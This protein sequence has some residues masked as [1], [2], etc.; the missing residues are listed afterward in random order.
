MAHSFTLI[1]FWHGPRKG[2]AGATNKLDGGVMPFVLD[3]SCSKSLERPESE[4]AARLGP[5]Q[6]PE[7]YCKCGATEESKGKPRKIPRSLP[8]FR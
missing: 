2:A 4:S 5:F 7:T 3:K 1:G 8:V 6:E